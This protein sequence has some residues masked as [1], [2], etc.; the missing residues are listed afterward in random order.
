M[1]PPK[2]APKRAGRPRGSRNVP[3]PIARTK[4]RPEAAT[5]RAVAAVPVAPGTLEYHERQRKCLQDLFDDLRSE[6]D[7]LPK[8]L[9]AYD[10][11]I[12]RHTKAIAELRGETRLTEQKIV[13][14]EAWRV[15]VLPKIARVLSEFP[16]AMIALVKA[17]EAGE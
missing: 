6:P 17:F 1:T 14:S 5:A 16:A 11:G 9:S 3:K 12:Q 10:A 13:Q 4:P 2:V 7:A 8:D 15:D